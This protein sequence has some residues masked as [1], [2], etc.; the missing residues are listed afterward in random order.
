MCGNQD[1]SSDSG[2]WFYYFHRFPNQDVEFAQIQLQV[3]DGLK[4]GNE[5]LKKMHEVVWKP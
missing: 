1:G 3:A 4:Q 2:W 5:A